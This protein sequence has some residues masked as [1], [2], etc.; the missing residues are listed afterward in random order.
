MFSFTFDSVSENE[1]IVFIINNEGHHIG[2]IF[3]RPYSSPSDILVNLYT[4][5]Q[6]TVHIIGSLSTLGLTEVTPT[7]QQIIITCNDIFD[8][9]F[10]FDVENYI[11]KKVHIQG[12]SNAYI[13]TPNNNVAHNPFRHGFSLHRLI[14]NG[15]Q[16]ILKLNDSIMNNMKAYQHLQGKQQTFL[17]QCVWQYI[18]AKLLIHPEFFTIYTKSESKISRR[19][20]WDL[21]RESISQSSNYEYISKHL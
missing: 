8:Y 21:K 15:L 10:I 18:R 20:H 1:F 19:T 3:R 9:C 12:M 7:D 4:Q 13:I 17:D 14:F 5:V 6:D 11:R 2:R 16:H